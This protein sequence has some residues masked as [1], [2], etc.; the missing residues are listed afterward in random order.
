MSTAVPRHWLRETR[1]RDQQFLDYLAAALIGAGGYLHYC[2]Y[3]NGY[4]AIP[5]IGTAFL[6]QVI[7]SALVAVALVAPLGFRIHAGRVGVGAPTIVRLAGIGISIGTLVAFVL[8]RLPGGIFNFQEQGFQP[9]PQSLITLLTEAGAVLV[10]LGAVAV[11]LVRHPGR[12]APV[13]VAEPSRKH[14]TSV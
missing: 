1:S 7:T 5:T 9:A 10:L 6:L 3:R 8:S 14:R 11:N 13:V 4:R 12:P 2:L